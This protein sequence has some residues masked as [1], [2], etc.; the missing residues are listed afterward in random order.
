VRLGNQSTTTAADGSFSIVA[1]PASTP[2]WRVT[3]TNVV[4]SYSPLGNYYV[5][6]LST[7]GHDAFLTA[8]PAVT[9]VPGEG[10]VIAIELRNG[11]GVPAVTTTSVPTALNGPYYSASTAWA[12]DVGTDAQGVAWIDGINVGTASISS[13]LNTTTITTPNVPVYDGGLT[14]IQVVFP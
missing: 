3:G 9:E 4:S 14:F 8:N 13:T 7:A 5:P 6:A 12:Q 2:V 1:D 11:S 10:S